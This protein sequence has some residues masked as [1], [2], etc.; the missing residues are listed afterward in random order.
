MI[1]RGEEKEKDAAAP[2][3]PAHL[4]RRFLEKAADERARAVH[5]QPI[6]LVATCGVRSGAEAQ[7]DPAGSNLRRAQRAQR[8][9]G[10]AARFETVGW[11]LRIGFRSEQA[12]AETAPDATFNKLDLMVPNLMLSIIE[13]LIT[14]RLNGKAIL[15]QYIMSSIFNF[16]FATTSFPPRYIVRFG[17]PQHNYA[18]QLARCVSHVGAGIDHR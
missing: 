5:R 7:R 3:H 8:R 17:L 1:S 6:K 10:W 18:G 15:H 2:R 9:R 13:H 16:Y 14:M 12:V 4:L 11:C